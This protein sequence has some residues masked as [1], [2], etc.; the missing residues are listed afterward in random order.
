MPVI[1][2]L[3]GIT[4][5]RAAIY[6]W[7]QRNHNDLPTQHTCIYSIW[8]GTKLMF[9]C[10]DVNVY[11]YACVCILYICMYTWCTIMMYSVYVCIYMRHIY[12]YMYYL[13][14]IFACIFTCLCSLLLY[15]HICICI[16][17]RVYDFIW[18]Y[19]TGI[20]HTCSAWCCYC[21]Y[22][23]TCMYRQTVMMYMYMLYEWYTISL[24]TSL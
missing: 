9:T 5:D 4:W 15:V 19:S 10:A 21:M 6:E 11:V 22:I 12:I 3:S 23:C 24:C 14:A 1:V 16:H 13:L 7:I 2:N 18:T 8:Y 20:V 17:V